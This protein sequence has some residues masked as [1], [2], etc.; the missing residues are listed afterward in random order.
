M[1]VYSIHFFGINLTEMYDKVDGE[2]TKRLR[3]VDDPEVPEDFDGEFSDRILDVYLDNDN[4]RIGK[5]LYDGAG[6]GQVTYVGV[7][8][9]KGPRGYAV[10]DEIEAE[11]RKIIEELPVHLAEAIRAIFGSIP[12]PEFHCVEAWG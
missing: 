2:L 3:A 8:V 5:S 4:R 6:Y 9:P 10:T 12:E 1:G 7:N 11:S